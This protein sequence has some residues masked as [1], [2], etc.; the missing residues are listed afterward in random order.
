MKLS[1]FELENELSQGIYFE[2]FN[3]EE[4]YW[5]LN[6]IHRNIYI[7]STIIRYCKITNEMIR[8]DFFIWWF[9]FCL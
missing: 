1:I 7:Y 5:D 2:Y 9:V 6:I 4:D 3:P 8:H